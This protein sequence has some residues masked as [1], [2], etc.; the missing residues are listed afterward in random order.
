[1]RAAA[2][3][4]TQAPGSLRSYLIRN[5]QTRHAPTAIATT[6]MASVLSP[7]DSLMVS[8]SADSRISAQQSFQH[9][10]PIRHLRSLIAH[11]R[12]ASRDL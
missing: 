10:A 9:P 4:D 11:M 1:M 8:L 5:H 2:V 6:T 12:Q 3:R 7:L